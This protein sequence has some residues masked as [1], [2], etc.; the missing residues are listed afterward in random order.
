MNAFDISVGIFVSDD[1]ISLGHHSIFHVTNISKI[2]LYI[3]QITL[4]KVRDNFTKFLYLKAHECKESEVKV[5]NI[6]SMKLRQRYTFYD[7]SH[8]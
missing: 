8:I 5:S 2:T 4:L 6:S 3:Y 1:F 7:F